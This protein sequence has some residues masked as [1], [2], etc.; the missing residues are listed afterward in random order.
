MCV[1]HVA[2]NYCTVQYYAVLCCAVLCMQRR[3][4]QPV[5]S[6]EADGTEVCLGVWK[7]SQWPTRAV[8]AR[9]KCARVQL[10]GIVQQRHRSPGSISIPY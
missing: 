8:S 9:R 6:Q 3:A 2:G 4:L 5:L 7:L 1:Q 10:A